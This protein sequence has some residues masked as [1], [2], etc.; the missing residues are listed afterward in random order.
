MNRGHHVIHRQPFVRKFLSAILAGEIIP[1]INIFP[2][3]A[4][5]VL[6]VSFNEIDQ[7]QDAGKSE[8]KPNGVNKVLVLFNDLNFALE[9]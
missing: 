5:E 7:A 9:E 4:D 3:E 6:R 2:A 8:F 1:Y